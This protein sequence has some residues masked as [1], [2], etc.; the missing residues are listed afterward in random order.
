MKIPLFILFL[1]L[2][3][4][5]VS[6]DRLEYADYPLLWSTPEASKSAADSVAK[7]SV[8]DLSFSCSD[9][10]LSPRIALEQFETISRQSK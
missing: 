10:S 5:I 3:N 4:Q 2:P 6:I 9:K 1:I 7:Q 8:L